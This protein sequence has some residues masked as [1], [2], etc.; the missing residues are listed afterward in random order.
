MKIHNFDAFLKERKKNA[1]QFRMFDEVFT[2]APSLPYAAMLE[3]M[4]YKKRLA[5]ETVTDDQ[6]LALF[7]TVFGQENVDKLASHNDF[8]VE[9]MIKL[10]HW[11]LEIY[12]M[13]GGN[14]DPKGKEL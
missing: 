4:A 3:F 9:L 8:D 7:T 1:P 13:S 5:D 10:L 12:G 11:A 2:L 14:S 6:I